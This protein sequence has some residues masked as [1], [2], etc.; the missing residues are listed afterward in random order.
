MMKI[1]N[2]KTD[3]TT[4]IAIIGLILFVLGFIAFFIFS[5]FN[6]TGVLDNCKRNNDNYSMNCKQFDW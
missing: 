3:K 4:I 6:H 5:D 2:M 1:D